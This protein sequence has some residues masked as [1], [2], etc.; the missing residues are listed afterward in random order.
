MISK[1]K[2]IRNIGVFDSVQET[3]DTKLSK[4]TL[5]YAENARG[6]TTLSAILRSL[7]SGEAFPIKERARLGSSHQPHVI[8]ESSTSAQPI[9]FQNDS[10]TRNISDIIIFEALVHESVVVLTLHRW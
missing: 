1:F 4:L 2:L 8:I 7:K 10:W 9:M 6:K 3:P 5:I